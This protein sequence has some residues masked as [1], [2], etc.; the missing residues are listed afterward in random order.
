MKK[1]KSFI[2]LEIM[3]W[4]FFLAIPVALFFAKCVTITGNKGGVKFMVSCSTFIV[5]LI[6]YIVFKKVI[7]KKYFQE[8]SAKIVNYTTQLETET[9]QT[10]IPLIEKALRKCL[11]LRTIFNVLPI[12]IVMGLVLVLVKALETDLVKLY[13]V[14]GY[15]TISYILGF[16][17]MLWQDASIKSKNRSE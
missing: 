6:I 14:V 7:L 2:A 13:A 3:K 15:C 1:D 5:A 17:C 12:I 10:K 9:D 4:V 16:I 8:L 11:T